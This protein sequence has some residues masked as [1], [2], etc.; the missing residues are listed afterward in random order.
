MKQISF[1]AVVLQPL[2]VWGLSSISLAADL[3]SVQT[4]LHNLL[5]VEKCE[6]SEPMFD[7]CLIG[8]NTI[9]A[10]DKT[11]PSKTIQDGQGQQTIGLSEPVADRL[12][13]L[14]LQA[15]K[16]DDYNAEMET[17]K[18]LYL[19]LQRGQ[20]KHLDYDTVIE[21][22]GALPAEVQEAIADAVNMA[23]GRAL[24]YNEARLQDE[25]NFN[26]QVAAIT[27]GLQI[28]NDHKSFVKINEQGNDLQKIKSESAQIKFFVQYGMIYVQ[29]CNL[30]GNGCW[31]QPPLPDWQH[32]KDNAGG[33]GFE[34]TFRKHW[35]VELMYIDLAPHNGGLFKKGI[36]VADQAYDPSGAGTL[37]DV[38]SPTYTATIHE[39]IKG[40]VLAIGREF[41]F[42]QS[43]SLTVRGGLFA[44]ET[45]T[46][47]WFI[48]TKTGR[49]F[50]WANPLIE[51]EHG[52]TPTI[53][54]EL[55]HQVT[56]HTAV[57]VSLDCLH[58]L[59]IKDAPF[60]SGAGLRR[61]F[62]GVTTYQIRLE[63]TVN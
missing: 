59:M 60:G 24:H 58:N 38:K 5:N 27:S 20:A 8:I 21:K 56:E 36:Y 31:H 19:A 61:G 40:L 50:A 26:D 43:W 35:S 41:Q 42:L 48:D 29:N 52:Y 46:Q 1:H 44:F 25:Q 15:T 47:F 17:Y 11:V 12:A 49:P 14:M 55:D 53:S 13:L 32:A 23:S 45:H 37:K 3:P 2:L 16:R 9:L 54:L 51:N 63:Y 30:G 39:Q 22:L 4:Q 62:C 33:I 57:G 7:A 28:S 10:L 34:V 18:T 6:A